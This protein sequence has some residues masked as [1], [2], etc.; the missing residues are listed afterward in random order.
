MAA[1]S[2]PTVGHLRQLAPFT[3]HAAIH[4][5]ELVRSVGVPL[6]ITSSRRT[7]TEQRAL[8]RAGN[9]LTLAS[10]HLSGSAF[11][12]DVH[13]FGRDEIPLW[14]FY[15][16]GWLGEQLG[17]RWGGRWTGLRDYGHFED[18]RVVR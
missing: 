7:G 4:M 1:G 6:T 8:V 10:K 11:D 2:D 15:Q 17:L 18:P 12:V 5:V 14:W 13:G 9:S 3:Q 16:L